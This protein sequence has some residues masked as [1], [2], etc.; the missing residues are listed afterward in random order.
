MSHRR[1]TLPCGHVDYVS[2][3]LCVRACVRVSVCACVHMPDATQSNV[4]HRC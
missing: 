3:Y 2:M 1:F 4:E